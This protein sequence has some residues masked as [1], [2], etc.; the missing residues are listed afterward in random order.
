ME[1]TLDLMNTLDDE[2][3]EFH[4]TTPEMYTTI[5]ATAEDLE[6]AEQ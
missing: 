4:C 3:V 1:N 5:D 6:Q 2:K